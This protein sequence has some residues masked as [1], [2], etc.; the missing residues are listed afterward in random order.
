MNE[1]DVR[2]C[3]A[4]GANMLGFVVN[5]PVP[6]PWGLSGEQAAKLI[7]FVPPTI[8]SCIVTGGKMEDI[9]SLAMELRP[10]YIQLHYKESFM[11][12]KHL[13]KVL[14]SHGIKTIK[15]ISI[16]EDGSSEMPEFSSAGE[17]IAAFADTEVA[18]VLLDTRCAASPASPSRQ[19]DIDFCRDIVQIPAKPLILS[20]GITGDNLGR[21]L[22]V[23]IPFGIDIL[24]GS[25]DSPGQKRKGKIDKICSII[26]QSSGSVQRPLDDRNF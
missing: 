7:A 4:A 11:E 20:G 10:D 2:L 26:N 19:L 25:E 5:Y 18:A 21:I 6:V 23:V 16:K 3:A 24:T 15:A 17:A 1:S 9:L 22:S 12:T 13:A 14:L 8:K